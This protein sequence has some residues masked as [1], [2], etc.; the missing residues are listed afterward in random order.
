MKSLSIW[1]FLTYFLGCGI[2]EE[3]RD[4][5]FSSVQRLEEAR[6]ETVVTEFD[7]ELD[8]VSLPTLIC[9]DLG[10]D[11]MDIPHHAVVLEH[12]EFNDTVGTCLTCQP[13]SW[14]NYD[15]MQIPHTALSACG[16]WFA[17]GGDYF[18]CIENNGHIEVY[19]GWQDEGQ[20]EE[21]DFDYHWEKTHSFDVEY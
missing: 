6:S 5:E 2:I 19:T 13:I 3:S 4:A 21:N 10:T 15:E 14:V 18:Y 8:K 1:F 20:A 17:G 12:G 16:G 11:E 7:S 9:V